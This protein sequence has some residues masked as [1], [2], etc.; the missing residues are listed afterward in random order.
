MLFKRL[1]GITFIVINAMYMNRNCLNFILPHI[2]SDSTF[3]DK[4]GIVHV[5]SKNKQRNVYIT[6]LYMI[7]FPEVKKQTKQNKY[8]QTKAKTQNK[9]C[10][11][12]DIDASF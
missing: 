3:F 8:K 11:N 4:F 10:Q 7:P 1:S 5:R 9:T 2:N 6:L 12:T